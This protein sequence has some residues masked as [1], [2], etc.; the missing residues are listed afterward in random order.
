MGGD[1]KTFHKVYRMEKGM[2]VYV[3]V[4]VSHL[5]VNKPLGMAGIKND[6]AKICMHSFTQQIMS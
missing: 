2:E 5:R 3:C 4:C 1:G 6:E